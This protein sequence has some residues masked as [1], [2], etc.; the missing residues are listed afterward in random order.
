MVF[1]HNPCLCILTYASFHSVYTTRPAVTVCCSVYS[2]TFCIDFCVYTATRRQ[3]G[4]PYR[5]YF[6]STLYWLPVYVM[7]YMRATAHDMHVTVPKSMIII[8]P[9]FSGYIKKIYKLCS[10]IR[11]RVISVSKILRWY[12]T[13]Y[14]SPVRMLFNIPSS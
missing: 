10:E 5:E 7:F 6:P 12:P 8:T 14:L 11:F 9:E 4:S 2:T 1:M 13:Q 3:K